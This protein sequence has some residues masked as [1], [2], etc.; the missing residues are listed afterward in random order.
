MNYLSRRSLGL[1]TLGVGM[2]LVSSVAQAATFRAKAVRVNGTAIS[3]TNSVDVVPG[4]VIQVDWLLSGW[5]TEI[6][7]LQTY[8]LTTDNAAMIDIEGQDNPTGCGSIHPLDSDGFYLR[9]A[10]AYLD[11]F[12]AGRGTCSSGSSNAGV[13]CVAA[14]FDCNL[15]ICR[16][17]STDGTFCSNDPTCVDSTCT[18]GTCIDGV[19]DEGRN[20]GSACALPENQCSG[21]GT[22]DSRADYVFAG[23][24]GVIITAIDP[25]TLFPNYRYGGTLFGQ[26]GPLDGSVC[27]GGTHASQPC[28]GNADCPGGQCNLDE[29]YV[30]TAI[31]VV[32]DLANGVFKY[33]LRGG[34]DSFVG[35]QAGGPAPV[36]KFEPLTIN[37]DNPVGCPNAGACCLSIGN[38]QELSPGLCENQG[39]VYAGDQTLC[40]EQTF[41]DCPTVV[42]TYPANCEND[43]RY[44]YGPDALPS[45]INARL[46]M[47]SVDVTMAPGTP[48]DVL[49]PGDFLYRSPQ[50]V[51]NPPVPVSI[52]VLH[53]TTVHIT[54]DK[55]FPQQKWNCLAM[56]CRGI[57][58]SDWIACWGRLPGD[59]DNSGVTGASD[60]LEIIDN[61]NGVLPQPLEPYSCDVDASGQCN[62][63][64]ILGVIDLL[65]GASN[66]QIYNNVGQPAG[67]CPTAG[68]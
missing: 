16:G 1:A 3:P 18:F 8:Q 23:I 45:D 24:Q 52:E 29:Y 43:A 7:S 28:D 67:G 58:Q 32:D 41:C 6:T 42:D 50:S 14:A 61:L 53:D 64:D 51:F 37:V 63:T 2:L 39:G 60:I 21:G 56:P 10:G 20:A 36:V 38:C 27:L 54:F 55:K 31:L 59:V 68:N 33:S 30:G 65:N 19:C 13:S 25:A 57:S 15:G 35:G 9:K 40:A 17:G 47:D 34:T 4:D 11:A 48:V 22:C 12:P 5:G 66:F 62:A 49:V 46:G 44:P 26:I